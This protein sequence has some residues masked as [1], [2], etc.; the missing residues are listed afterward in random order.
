MVWKYLLSLPP[1][2]L[3]PKLG[4]LVFILSTWQR[5]GGRV[6]KCATPAAAVVPRR[7][8]SAG[9]E[10]GQRL[11]RQAAELWLQWVA[12]A[13]GER[14]KRTKSMV[15]SRDA[16]VRREF[17]GGGATSFGGRGRHRGN[18]RLWIL[19]LFCCEQ[20]ISK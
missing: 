15:A 11:Q 20:L 2:L 13:S 12:R 17:H 3:P 8:W 5:R 18:G 6:K 4:S 10:C 9:V 7:L 14:G 16:A 19:F 1:A